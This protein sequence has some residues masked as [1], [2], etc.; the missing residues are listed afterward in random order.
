MKPLSKLNDEMNA[1]QFSGRLNDI[2][3]ELLNSLGGDRSGAQGLICAA[4]S[5]KKWDENNYRCNSFL[6]EGDHAFDDALWKWFL[7]WVAGKTN[8]V[9][10][11]EALNEVSLERVDHLVVSL[12]KYVTHRH[13][14]YENERAMRSFFAEN[15]FPIWETSGLADCVRFVL[16][17]YNG[18][19]S[20]RHVVDCAEAV[21][22]RRLHT[23][24]CRLDPNLN[25][26]QQ[27]LYYD[28]TGNDNV[29][30][31]VNGKLNLD[32]PNQVFVLGGLSADDAISLAELKDRLGRDTDGEVKSGRFLGDSFVGMLER[33]NFSKL[34]DLIETEKWHFHLFVAQ[35]L[36]YGLVDIVDSI[37][38]H[39]GDFELKQALFDVV[40]ADL[41]KA[42]RV[43]DKFEYPDI[44]SDRMHQFLDALIDL[45]N[46]VQANKGV[47]DDR[48]RLIVALQSGKLQ[49]ELP[50]IQEEAKRILVGDYFPFYHSRLMTFPRSRFA[51]DGRDDLFRHKE[52]VCFAYEGS[53]IDWRVADSKK[54]PMIQ[55]C[56]YIVNVVRRFIYFADRNEK[57]VR[58][59]IR[60][61]TQEGRDRLR[62]FKDIWV[63]S[64]RYNPL[65]TDYVV[66]KRTRGRVL[67]CLREI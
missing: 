9:S 60:G 17:Q 53:E 29:V 7:K 26:M 37:E 22:I 36:Y 21:C 30:R 45:T 56:D 47:R 6:E 50:F 66:S 33:E 25:L 8:D 51:F 2:Y 42:V 58:K 43:L 39:A 54:E 5:F 48:K 40:R 10:H 13:R 24:R 65:L 27:S 23:E 57:L 20:C 14:D 18:D 64:E 32:D 44:K 16:R 38:N 55:L 3:N 63:R 41:V 61:L 12:A 31:I 19:C 1:E 49:G 35:P 34:M 15:D 11:L 46:D 62:K 28:E 4:L 59:D 67:K 52:Q